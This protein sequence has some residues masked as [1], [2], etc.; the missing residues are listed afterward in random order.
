MSETRRIVLGIGVF[1]A[2]VLTGAIVIRGLK[3]NVVSADP[4]WILGMVL[5]VMST[6]AITGMSYNDYKFSRRN[7]F[8]GVVCAVFIVG[9]A[10][11]T[12]RPLETLVQRER[13]EAMKNEAAAVM[14]LTYHFESAEFVYAVVNVEDGE[15]GQS[16]QSKLAYARRLMGDFARE[17]YAADWGTQRKVAKNIGWPVTDI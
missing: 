17:Y 7:L 15:T 16:F 4:G 10:L 6:A 9:L 13:T 11:A 12:N 2:W 14:R 1:L 5:C 3:A 8:E